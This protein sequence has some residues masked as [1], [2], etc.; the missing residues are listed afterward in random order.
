MRTLE[1]EL[2]NDIAYF[3]KAQYVFNTLQH[4]ITIAGIYCK[5]IL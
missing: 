1:H 5:Y 2:A 4:E 3:T